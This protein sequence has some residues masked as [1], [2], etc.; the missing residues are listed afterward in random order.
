[1]MFWVGMN[2]AS[3]GMA[4]GIPRPDRRRP[5]QWSSGAIK[6]STEIPPIQLGHAYSV[7]RTDGLGLRGRGAGGE[8]R[9][10]GDTV[11]AAR[12]KDAAITA[13]TW[14][15]E[16]ALASGDVDEARRKADESVAATPTG[17]RTRPCRCWLAHTSRSREGR[18]DSAERFGPPGS[19]AARRGRGISR[20]ARQSRVPRRD[21]AGISRKPFGGG[22]TVWRRGRHP[23]THSAE[24]RF[25][26]HDDEYASLVASVREYIGGERIR[27]AMGGGRHVV[28]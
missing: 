24:V 4:A 14:P 10:A 22:A 2:R 8:I 15:A 18:P 20:H 19:R 28:D 1:M 3:Q 23:A 17:R 16:V 5:R 26:L 9:R 12:A 27:A 13:G 7:W 21:C 25:K 6:A 11:H